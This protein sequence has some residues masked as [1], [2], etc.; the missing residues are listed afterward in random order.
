MD[1]DDWLEVRTWMMIPFITFMFKIL[2]GYLEFYKILL[3][4]KKE[5]KEKQMS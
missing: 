4:L 5:K 2:N 1:D 3:F